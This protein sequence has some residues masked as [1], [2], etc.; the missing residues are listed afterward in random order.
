MTTK[1]MLLAEID[2]LPEEDLR[3]LLDTARQLARRQ[4]SESGTGG[5]VDPEARRLWSS[6]P[7][8]QQALLLDNVFCQKCRQVTTII[9]YTGSVERGDLVLDG[10][11]QQCGSEVARVIEFASR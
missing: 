10:R 6:I 11:C 5:I 1:D 7:K 3:V 9:E 2:K 4:E 8:E